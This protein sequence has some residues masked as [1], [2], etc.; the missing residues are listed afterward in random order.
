[1]KK[2][3][4]NKILV[5]SIVL[6]AILTT[7]LLLAKSINEKEKESK[8]NYSI[9]GTITKITENNNITSIQIEG[10]IAEDTQYDTGYITIT[11]N[12]EVT[13]SASKTILKEGMLVEAALDLVKETYPITA[14]AKKVNVIDKFD[15]KYQD[16]VDLIA[17]TIVSGNKEVPETA[18]HAKELKII[19]EDMYL[20]IEGQE[21]NIK[22]KEV[23]IYTYKIAERNYF[24]IYIDAVSL[25][26]LA[27]E[28]R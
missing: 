3:T 6:I 24:N 14:D 20:E 26:F 8:D 17:A 27:T 16:Y 28:K 25:K 22:G 10:W 2:E 5:V 18:E 12:T 19:I 7:V 23:Y 21:T 11:K 9:R 13:S 4:K 1:M 15:K